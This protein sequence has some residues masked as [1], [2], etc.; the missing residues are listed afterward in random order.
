MT[1]IPTVRAC[2]PADGATVHG[3][4]C[5]TVD[6][7]YAPVYPPRALA[8]FKRVHDPD[9][10]AERTLTGLVLLAEVNGVAAA[11]GSLVEDK[12]S[13]VFVRP[14]FQGLGLGK[15]L[16][17]DLEDGARQAGRRQIRLHVSLISRQF[18]ESLGYTIVEAVSEDLGNGER[19]D[20]WNAEKSLSDAG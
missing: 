18:Y 7:S 5:D 13:A 2:G 16:M 6:V 14:S 8:F 17:R 20:F 15:R 4:I 9:R 19:L 12:I 10:I 3:L 1:D 11:T